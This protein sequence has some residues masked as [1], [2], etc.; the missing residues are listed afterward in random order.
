MEVGNLSKDNHE[1]FDSYR[2]GIAYAEVLAS[3]FS[4]IESFRKSSI[5]P[6][7]N[8][9]ILN[10]L[11]HRFTELNIRDKPKSV[12]DMCSRKYE[13]VEKFLKKHANDLISNEGST[14]ILK[15][16]Y[17]IP[18]REILQWRW[19]SLALPSELILA[20]ADTGRA[21]RIRLLDSSLKI[22]EP[23]AH[24]H[25]HA[26]AGISF[27]QI[28]NQ[29]GKK[30]PSNKNMDIPEGFVNFEEWKSWLARALVTKKILEL[31]LQKGYDHVSRE[32]QLKPVILTALRDMING[33]L[34]EIS[35]LEE[36]YLWFFSARPNEVPFQEKNHLGKQKWI[37][38]SKSEI[39]FD[40][41]CLQFIETDTSNQRDMFRKLWIQTTRIKVLF[42]RHLIYDPVDQCLGK[43]TKRFKRLDDY[44]F[45]ENAIP[46]EVKSAVKLDKD[47]GVKKLELRKTPGKLSKLRQ[48]HYEAI[49]IKKKSGEPKLSWTL[50][51]IRSTNSDLK[52]QI[53]K[54]YITANKL[55]RIFRL[56]PE[57]L[58]NIRGLDVA[59]H[60]SSGPLWSVS[61]P[62]QQVR[63]ASQ[64]AC[65]NYPGIK[66]LK[67]TIHAGEDFTHL[68]SG[69]RSIHEP[70][71]WEIMNRG[72]RIGHAMALGWD[73]HEWCSRYPLIYQPRL[74]RMFDIAWMLGFVATRRLPNVPS[75]LIE[76]AKKELNDHLHEWTGCK[77]YIYNHFVDIFKD[78]GKPRIWEKIDGPYWH[79]STFEGNVKLLQKIL[80]EYDQNESDV[81]EVNT[82]DD[83]DLLLEIRNELVKI[84]ARWRTPLEINPSSN[85]LIGNLPYP[86]AQ[87]LFKLDSFDRNENLG[88]V[89]TLSADDPICFS[90][91]LADE[92]AY[93][94]AGLVVL[95]KESPTFAHEWLVRIAQ[96][97]MRAAF[98]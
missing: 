22:L 87:P 92:Y 24:L 71:L 20:A 64:E 10:H 65:L 91:C 36:S 4:C 27:S 82:E 35:R 34:S 96:A 84:L 23:I 37:D 56:K 60:E 90:T 89:L 61:A 25:F 2:W 68:L 88:L 47:I 3:P 39:I 17:Q 67:I 80:E 73:P 14:A 52:G 16:D 28:W 78:I 7:K 72:D 83:G 38:Y 33:E 45:Q 40:R 76:Q 44:I 41:N 62:L 48:M 74:E 50:H 12:L 15:P 81:V 85:L 5:F 57:L 46:N 75:T 54:H 94:W 58:K 1:R 69:L 95:G 86:L 8:N 59:G 98:E 79:H 42:Y 18:G 6:Y 13:P 9:D 19:I 66:P 26:T 93:S 31:W 11:G 43:F 70:F 77:N 63:E 30:K 21:R 29:L 97:S 32:L 53:Y 49:K 55:S 51:F